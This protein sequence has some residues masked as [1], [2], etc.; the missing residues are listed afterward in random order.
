[1]MTGGSKTREG[2]GGIPSRTIC[3]SETIVMTKKR[4]MG[5]SEKVFLP[6]KVGETLRS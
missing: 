6:V 1:M 2:G 5:G 4:S 3:K